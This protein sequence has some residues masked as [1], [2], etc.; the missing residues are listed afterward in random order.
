MNNIVMTRVDARLVHGQVAVRWSK[1][2]DAKKIAVVDDK[3]AKDEFLTEILYMAAPPGVKTTVYSVDQA[4]EIWKGEGFGELN[5]IIIL[6]NVDTAKRCFDEGMTFAS[7]NVGQQP[8]AP[9]RR[10]A[11]NTVQLSDDELQELIDMA[12]AGVDV[13]FHPTP[14]DIKTDLATVKRKMS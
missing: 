13:F 8:K 12:D 11:N 2:L 6:P 5:T 4:V 14:E 10:R 3:T 1:V 7:L 9:G